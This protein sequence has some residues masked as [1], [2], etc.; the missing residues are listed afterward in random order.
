MKVQLD[1]RLILE[2]FQY[3]TPKEMNTPFNK[4]FNTTVGTLAGT[5]LGLG[6]VAGL[7]GAGVAAPSAALIAGPVAGAIGGAY[8]A[9]KYSPQI[10]KVADRATTDLLNNKNRSADILGGAAALGTGVLAA[11]ALN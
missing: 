4:G 2:N 8:L 9:N 11:G 3:A 10:D 1:K 6:G 5:K 7:V